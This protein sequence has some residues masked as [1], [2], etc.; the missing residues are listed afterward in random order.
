MC[1]GLRDPPG[2]CARQNSLFT[3]IVFVPEC[4]Q[5]KIDV[6][7]SERST[8]APLVTLQP[9]DGMLFNIENNY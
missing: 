3:V 5:S 4:Q 2:L 9:A 6:N 7:E 1:P 8:T